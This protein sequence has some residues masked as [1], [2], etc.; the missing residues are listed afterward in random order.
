MTSNSVYFASTILHLYAAASIALGRKNE[1]A[2]LFFIDQPEYKEYPLYSIVKDWELSPFSTT[3]LL[4]GRFKGSLNKLKKRKQLFKNIESIISDLKPSDIFVGN[5]RRIEF[6][7]AMHISETL[8]LNTKGHYM[9]EGTFTVSGHSTTS[10][11]PNSRA[12]F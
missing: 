12:L 7:F 3:K 8:N 1:I 5:D 2:H 4:P 11:T 9:D 6:Q 10:F